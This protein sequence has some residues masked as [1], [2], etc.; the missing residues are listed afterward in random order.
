MPNKPTKQPSIK[1]SMDHIS[2]RLDTVE[3]NGL[4]TEVIT[5]A[6]KAMKE[7]PS[8]TIPEAFEEGCREWDV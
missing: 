1:E 4:Y 2:K 8:L 5:F 3:K 7:N 6:L